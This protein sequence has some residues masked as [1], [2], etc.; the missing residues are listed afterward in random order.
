MTE[1]LVENAKVAAAYR[2]VEHHVKEK[3]SHR[4]GEKFK[5]GSPIEVTRL[6]YA[7][8]KNYIEEKYGG[9]VILRMA[10]PAEYGHGDFFMDWQ[11]P[12]GVEDR[13][14]INNEILLMPGVIE[15]GIFIKMAHKAY[16][17]MPDGNVFERTPLN[18]N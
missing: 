10:G 1:T 18:I 4:I 15:T 6:A 12:E 5:K 14:K 7:P 16:F 2:A 17:G 9:K 11:F 13:G 3:N 8:V